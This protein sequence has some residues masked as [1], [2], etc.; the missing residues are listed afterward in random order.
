MGYIVYPDPSDPI[1]AKNYEKGIG[2]VFEK[3]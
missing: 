2:Q 3:K 1:I